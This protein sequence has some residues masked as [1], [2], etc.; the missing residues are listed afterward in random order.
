MEPFEKQATKLLLEIEELT[1]GD[2]PDLLKQGQL[3]D[4]LKYQKLNEARMDALYRKYWAESDKIKKNVKVYPIVIF[5]EV[6][7]ANPSVHQM[8]LQI[9]DEGQ[10]QMSN[11]E[12][13]SFADAFIILTGNVGAREINALMRG[14]IGFHTGDAKDK[15]RE[16]DQTVN[17]ELKKHF[18][19]ELIGRLRKE[20]AI[21]IFNELNEEAL[22]NILNLEL[23]K[24]KKRLDDA[25][26]KIKLKFTA[27]A[28]RHL[29]RISNTSEYGARELSGMVEHWL[30]VPLAYAICSEEIEKG[31]ELRVD[32]REGDL[33]FEKSKK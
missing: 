9:I 29:L 26:L 4:L 22:L 28:K 23:D 21:I 18:L 8:L 27:E 32:F 12:T 11:G 6:E 31:D 17:A 14:K 7:K 10:L 19:P 5:D 15:T 3:K 13:T 2:L 25:K 16:I 20:N 30:L 33:I 24:I 1:R